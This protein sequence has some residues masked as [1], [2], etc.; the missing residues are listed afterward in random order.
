MVALIR[1]AG[2]K[3]QVT[4]STTT[5]L[6]NLPNPNLNPNPNLQLFYTGVYKRLY[7]AGYVQPSLRNK[8]WEKTFVATNALHRTKL[9]YMVRK[10]KMSFEENLSIYTYYHNPSSL[11]N[12]NAGRFKA[13]NTI[14]QQEKKEN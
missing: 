11:W 9:T 6:E 2:K 5:L 1:Q 10:N 13:T 3:Y 4:Y 8:C 12:T 7:T 14:S